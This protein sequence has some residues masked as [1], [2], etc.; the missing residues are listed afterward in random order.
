MSLKDPFRSCLLVFFLNSLR[1]LYDPQFLPCF[2]KFL[3]PLSSKVF[4]LSFYQHSSFNSSQVSQKTCKVLS[5]SLPHS[6][7]LFPTVLCK[8]KDPG[9]R[10]LNKL[11]HREKPQKRWNSFCRHDLSPRQWMDKSGL[12]EVFKVS[13]VLHRFPATNTRYF[14]L[15]ARL[16]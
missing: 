3:A 8:L 7:Q 15:T 16:L 5:S 4:F 1:F 10:G 11:K 2:I 14:W 13:Q 6:H 12:N 9:I